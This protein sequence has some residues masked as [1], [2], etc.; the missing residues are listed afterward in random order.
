MY[1]VVCFLDPEAEIMHVPHP[2]AWVVIQAENMS[3]QAPLHVPLAQRARN[4]SM[5]YNL[6]WSQHNPPALDVALMTVILAVGAAKAEI[7][8]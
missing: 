6:A 7:A 8:A 5:H 1:F 3:C 2:C 4:A